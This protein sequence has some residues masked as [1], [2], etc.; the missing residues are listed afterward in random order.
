MTVHTFAPDITYCN[1]PLEVGF[2]SPHNPYDRRNFSGTPFFAARALGGRDT[3]KSRVLFHRPPGQLDR[4][5]RRTAPKVDLGQID[6]AGLD[7]V[8]GLVAS[9]L[10]EAVTRQRPDLPVLHVTDATP[11]FLRDA[12]GWRVPAEADACETRL[13]AQ[14]DLIVYSSDQLAA[15]APGDLGMPG[16]WTETVPFGVNFDTLPTHCPE[17]PSLEALNLLFVGMD[18]HRKGGDIAVEALARLRAS[19]RKATLTIV[20]RC[21][22]QHRAQPGIKYAGFL[23]KNRPRDAARLARLYHNAHLLLLPSRADCSPMVVAEA[24]AHGTPVLA[25]DTGGIGSLVGQDGSGGRLLPPFT[26]PAE[27]A[28]AIAGMTADHEAYAFLSDAGFD[29]ATLGLS[30]DNWARQI[31]RLARQAMAA[32]TTGRGLKVAAA[33]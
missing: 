6:L 14:A 31:E 26:A 4:L 8:V 12:Y 19:G 7:V 17:K 13:A 27:W 5:L 22:E 3:L 15:R 23:N 24:L 29:R 9:P 21:P 10:L 32:R 18:W 30:W 16:L 20:G 11:A 2:L 1:R 28:A 25:T 33:N